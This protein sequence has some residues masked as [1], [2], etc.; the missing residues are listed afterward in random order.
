MASFT[1]TPR[2][3]KTGHLRR[4]EESMTGNVSSLHT[5]A[6]E[7]VSIPMG[8]RRLK[9]TRRQRLPPGKGRRWQR[10][11]VRF[12]DEFRGRSSPVLNVFHQECK[13]L[14]RKT[15]VSARRRLIQCLRALAAAVAAHTGRPVTLRPHHVGP[16]DVIQAWLTKALRS[17][18]KLAANSGV[19]YALRAVKNLA[20]RARV[21]WL[22]G[23]PLGSWA[24][25]RTPPK[26]L[27]SDK[28][29]AQ[30][31]YVSRALPEPPQRV[32]DEALVKHES[33]LTSVFTTPERHLCSA[34]TFARDWGQK[35]LPGSI[36]EMQITADTTLSSSA[37]Y[38]H[39][40]RQGGAF[41]RVQEIL[42]TAEEY[43][44]NRP[45]GLLD[46]EWMD[47][48]V[49]YRVMQACLPRVERFQEEPCR[50]KVRVVRER[51]LKARIVTASETEFIILGH[52]ARRKILQA[53][54]RDKHCSDV[55]QGNHGK[56]VARLSGGKGEL[57]SCDLTAAS[58]L[59]PLDLVASLVEGLLD[60]QL[61]DCEESLG[62]R[63]CTA[64]MSIEWGE[65][66]SGTTSSRGILM[67]LPTT[68]VLLS[69]YHLWLW[70][71]AKMI[72]PI[73]PFARDLRR[74]SVLYSICGDD[75]VAIAPSPVLDRYEENLTQTGG[76]IS[77]DKHARSSSRCVFTEE[78]WQFP[79]RKEVWRYFCKGSIFLIVRDARG[80]KRRRPITEHCKVLHVF[81]SPKRIQTITLRGLTGPQEGMFIG[82]SSCVPSGG[83]ES[84]AAGAAVEA[85]IASGADPLRVW[86]V[87]QTLMSRDKKVV[88][89]LGVPVFLPRCLGG[90]GFI[91]KHGYD[92]PLK[93]VAS[94]RDRKIAA[95]LASGNVDSSIFSR[96]WQQGFSSP[97][98]QM[99]SDEVDSY[100]SLI[101]HAKKPSDWK[102]EGEWFDQG[103]KAVFLQNLILRID[104]RLSWALPHCFR[105]K[106]GK[107]QIARLLGNARR[108]TL[109]CWPAV[110]PMKGTVRR[111]LDA[112]REE[113][114]K[115]IYLP[116]TR[117]PLY[118]EC[119]GRPVGGRDKESH[120]H[121]QR[122]RFAVRN[123]RLHSASAE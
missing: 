121:R 45:P 30:F 35:Y 15:K 94:K 50:S 99:A 83:P 63:A 6:P 29:F 56:A 2:P 62:L 92:A 13:R 19:E 95:I 8:G 90:A 104:R 65:G 58:D 69:L 71:D 115:H 41:A 101:R 96:K 61:L 18:Q 48:V 84:F 43:C 26:Q 88:K 54:K 70:A 118:P 86:A 1:V 120:A 97:T 5:S 55:L 44:G 103:E 68:W 31:S 42:E 72:S 60:T 112:I 113:D 117:D 49:E 23:R 34:R 81:G 98:F 105:Q 91:T 110:A 36:S 100:L 24:P 47:R 64:P 80:R 85:N 14:G 27:R 16:K 59:M 108:K 122:L 51:G 25:V 22:N 78:L 87:Q 53:L 37:C 4:T 10:R 67:G 66:G 32:V 3:V 74:A 9:D 114:A 109:K 111:A 77:G 73:P 39:N 20:A 38:T 52:K 7:S 57:L 89:D 123:A 82:P 46:Q 11:V 17:V 75:A 106:T 107:F 102:P 21:A 12:D 93:R 40:T 28:F 119:F 76:D 33:V 116:P 79:S